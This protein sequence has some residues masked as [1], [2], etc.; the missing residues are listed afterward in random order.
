[1]ALGELDPQQAQTL[2]QLIEAHW[3]IIEGSEL[4][5]RIQQLESKAGASS[6]RQ[7]ITLGA[8]D[9]PF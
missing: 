1:V 6:K 7:K 4:S 5:L 3:R 9:K 8:F 2:H